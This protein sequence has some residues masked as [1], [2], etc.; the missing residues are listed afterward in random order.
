MRVLVVALVLLAGCAT[1]QEKFADR[2]AERAIMDG[3]KFKTAEVS[4]ETNDE[5]CKFKTQYGEP[6]Q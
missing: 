2:C 3:H 1:A 6:R 4:I 5:T